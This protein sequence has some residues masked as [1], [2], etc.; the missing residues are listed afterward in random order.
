MVIDF[1]STAADGEFSETGFAFGVVAVH[2]DLI[3]IHTFKIL[4]IPTAF[5][6]K[7]E[8]RLIFGSAMWA[9][10]RKSLLKNGALI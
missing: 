6:T 3:H 2:S 10:H 8:S 7:L 1:E 4:D 5:N 9:F